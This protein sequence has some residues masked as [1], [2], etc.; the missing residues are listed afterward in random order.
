[1]TMKKVKMARTGKRSAVGATMGSKGR[2]YISG[3]IRG[4]KDYESAFKIAAIELRNDGW[5]V[6]SP[7]ETDFNGATLREIF[8][9]D[10]DW[11]TRMADAMYMLK[12]WEA[13]SGAQ[14]EWALARALGLRIFYED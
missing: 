7:I 13:S 3:P 2:V 12:G 14:A 8:A 6:L 10:C 1:M 4:K 9:I 11:I 5:A